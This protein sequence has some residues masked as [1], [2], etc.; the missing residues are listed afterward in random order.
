MT[1]KKNLVD[2]ARE[3][4]ASD[5]YPGALLIHELADALEKA[6]EERDQAIAHDRQ[7]YPTA[8]AYEQAVKALDKK[9]RELDNLRA[10]QFG[11]PDDRRALEL[12]IG[13]DPVK[14]SIRDHP[15]ITY[16]FRTIDDRDGLIERILAA[17]FARPTEWEYAVKWT[18]DGE[19]PHIAG[20]GTLEQIT[21]ALTL[22][23]QMI[24]RGGLPFS[25][26]MV[27]RRKAG[28]PQ[29]VPEGEQP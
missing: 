21:A 13:Y 4:A 10:R 20:W 6:I 9:Q 15:E 22:N 14:L 18:E 24:E 8:W 16:E 27:Q 25:V 29:P 3:Y 1:E 19:E 7:P 26:H 12:A 11:T 28:S 23:Q 17:G 5:I 2:Q